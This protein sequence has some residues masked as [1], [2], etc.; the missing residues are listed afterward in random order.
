[1]NI[2]WLVII[3]VVCLGI[4]Y[5]IF[6]ITKRDIETE[7]QL[8]RQIV[9]PQQPTNYQ[10]PQLYTPPNLTTKPT[11]AIA[12]KSAI[13]IISRPAVE[14]EKEAIV[15]VIT[16]KE[17][18]PSEPETSNTSQPGIT[19]IGKFPSKKEAQEMNSAGIVMY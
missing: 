1:M 16:P 13:T 5:I 19:K 14:P 2:K 9:L 10:Q 3:S 18:I 11:T 7:L 6:A 4:I 15:P 8:Q 12:P 17:N